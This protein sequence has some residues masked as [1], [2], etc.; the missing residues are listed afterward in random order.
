M[1]V[2]KLERAQALLPKLKKLYPDAHCALIHQNAFQL[3]VATLMSAQ[4]T[5]E[6]VNQV[7]PALFKTYP[8][9]YSMAQA[10]V[11][12]VEV[13]INQINYYKTKARHLIE[14]SQLLVTQ[15]GGEVPAH[16]E[17]LI[18]LPGVGRKTANVVLGNAF[19]IASGVV[20]DTH[21]GRLSRRIGLTKQQD[22]E[23]VNQELQ[24]LFP[25]KDW[26]QLSHWLIYHGRQVCSARA[27]NCTDCQLQSLCLR[28]I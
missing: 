16:L 21:V 2:T 25:K 3:L 9:C 23:K 28:R 11:V 26:V 1:L 6:K 27:P 7:T 20:V 17:K 12:K 14:M 5:D 22:P 4:T 8:D 19:G 15:F 13:L 18:S 24:K 10:D